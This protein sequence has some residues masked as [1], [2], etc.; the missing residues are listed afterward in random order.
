M[1]NKFYRYPPR[2]SSGAGTFSDNIVGFQ[3]VDGGGLTQGNFEFTTS[4]VEKVNR[5]F[6]IGSF[7]EPISLDSLSINSVL[8]SKSIIAKDFRVY[9]N[10]D[11]SQITNFSLYGS[12]SKRISTS[13][14]K[15]INFFPGALELYTLNFDLTT[16]NTATN[17]S[18][19]ITEDTTTFDIEITEIR[20]PF[21]IDYSVNATRNLAL[22]EFEVSPLRNLTKEY[23]KY[24]LFVG[25]NEYPVLFMTP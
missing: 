11:L 16:G 22:K 13:I 3:L 2:P 4:I 14:E 17:S 6:N 23:S 10:F 25:D 20:N 9:P 18:Y 8:E 5:E 21:D 15:V 24:S 1:A 12:L 19:D 7:S